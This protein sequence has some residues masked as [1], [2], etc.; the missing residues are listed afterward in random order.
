MVSGE[1]SSAVLP[2]V[3]R[4][5]ELCTDSKEE[6]EALLRA[7]NGPVKDDDDVKNRVTPWKKQ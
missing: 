3:H 4:H 7:I 5:L 6:L 1:D 2:M